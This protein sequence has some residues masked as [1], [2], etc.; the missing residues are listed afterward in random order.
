MDWEAIAK[1]LQHHP[2]QPI[3]QGHASAVLALV[4]GERMIF[5]VRA[6]S[7]HRQPGEICLPGGKIEPGETPTQ[8]ALRETREELGIPM[9]AIEVVGPL[10]A[11]FHSDQ[12]VV[13]AT[14]AHCA[15]DV[16]Q[17]VCPSPAEVAEVFSVPLDW[18]RANPPA[19]YQYQQVFT[20]LEDLPPQM[21]RWLA[22]YPTLRQGR[23][24]SYEG[25]LIWGLT[26]R[27]IALVLE[28]TKCPEAVSLGL[29]E[30][31]AGPGTSQKEECP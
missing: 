12:R 28:A 17:Q 4:A 22:S 5:E 13:Y 27:V 10:G 16:L 20:A 15:P 18:F 26:A 1:Q 25:K 2:P 24:W 11:L 31:S 21:A 29:R 30:E 8:A 6:A 9:E 14:L 19:Y 3:G 23:Y 7:L